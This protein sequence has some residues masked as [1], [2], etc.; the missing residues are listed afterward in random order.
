MS[1]KYWITKPYP[2]LENAKDKWI[3]ILASSLFVALF[4]VVHPFS[5]KKLKLTELFD[6]PVRL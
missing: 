6:V 2:F 5:Q 4:P 3:I 1:V